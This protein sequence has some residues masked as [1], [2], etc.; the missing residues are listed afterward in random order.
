M[1]FKIKLVII[2]AP[3]VGK[4]SLV[5]KFVSQHFSNDY[6]ASIGTNIFIKKIFFNS[7]NKKINVTLQL[8]DIAGQERWTLMRDTYYK[9]THGAL[10]IVDLTRKRTLNQI[11]EFWYP[12]LK[13]NCGQIPTILIGNK[14]DLYRKITDNEINHLGLKLGID[15]VITTSAKI[16]MNVDHAFNLISKKTIENFIT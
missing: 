3:A 12:D 9:G 2:G 5:K 6:K 7:N 8:W 14:N 15:Y 1:D 11:E 16:G 4:T 13:K 10:L